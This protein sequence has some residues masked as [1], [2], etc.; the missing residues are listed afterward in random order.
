M[1]AAVPMIILADGIP[2]GIVY[3]IVIVHVVNVCKIFS[4]QFQY[5]VSLPVNRKLCPC[6]GL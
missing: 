3:F 2:P 5:C 6:Y 4:R 1:D